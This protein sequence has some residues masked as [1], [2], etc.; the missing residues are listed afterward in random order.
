M[1]FSHLSDPAYREAIDNSS[2]FNARLVKERALRLPFLD[3]QTGVA[4][5]IANIIVLI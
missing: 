5:S 1:N 4:Q 3:A 2:T